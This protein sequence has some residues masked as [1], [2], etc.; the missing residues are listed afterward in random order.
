M[1]EYHMVQVPP[2]VTVRAGDTRGAAAGYLQSVVDDYARQGWEFYSVESIGIIEQP[3][4]GCL[5][6]LLGIHARL[7]ETYVIVFRRT[8]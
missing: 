7:I 5:A 8:R 4:C 3:G 1:F 2:N 6:G